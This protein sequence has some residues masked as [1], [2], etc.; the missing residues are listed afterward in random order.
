MSDYWKVVDVIKSCK[1]SR[2]NNVAYR[3]VQLYE[4][5]YPVSRGLAQEL[6]DL[7]DENLTNICSRGRFV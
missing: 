7:C 4:K 2:Q 6:Y 1:T 5:K 3:M